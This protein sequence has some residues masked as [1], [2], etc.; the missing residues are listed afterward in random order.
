MRAREPIG[1]IIPTTTLLGDAMNLRGHHRV[2]LRGTFPVSLPGRSPRRWIA[3]ALGLGLLVVAIACAAEPYRQTR[4]FRAVVACERHAA[5]CFD[6]EPGTIVGR[7]T[8]TTT[9]TTTHADGT[10]STTTTT[11]HEVTWQRTDGSRQARDVSSGFYATT[12]EGR[13]ADLLLWRGTVVA[14]EVMGGAEWFLPESGTSL[15]RWLH[16]AFLG[17][18]VLLWGLLF[19]WWDGFFMLTFRAFAWMFMSFAPVNLTTDALAYGLEF[20]S[21]LVV[22]I[23]FG[24][25]FTGIAGAML[26]GSLNRW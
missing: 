12:Q 19:G 26:V 23:G 25:V 20:D 15:G 8:Y 14:I 18:G 13:P 10:S 17:L 4:E 3:V 1:R 24:I 7:R 21:G 5:G 16:L 9:T 11:H 22:T 6:R 2:R